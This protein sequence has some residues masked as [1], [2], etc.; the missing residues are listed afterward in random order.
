MLQDF[1]MRMYAPLLWMY[2]SLLWMYPSLLR[3]YSSLLWQEQCDGRAQTE[4][5]PLSLAKIR[6]CGCSQPC[7]GQA[8]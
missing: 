1:L 3:M 6:G 2:P 5:R 4:L 8:A 7:C